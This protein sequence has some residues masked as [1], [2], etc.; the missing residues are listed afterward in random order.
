[1]TQTEDWVRIRGDQLVAA[2]RRATTCASPRS[3]GRRTSSIT[4]RC[5]SS[6]IPTDTEVFVDE[7]FSAARRR[8]WRCSAMRR[9]RAG[10][11]AHGTTQ[12]ATSPTLVDARAT[13]ATWR[14]SRAARIRASPRDHFV[15]FE[16]GRERPRR[17][18]TCS[19]SRGLDLS[20]RQQHQRRH[21]AGRARRSRAASRSKRR[22]RRAVGD[23]RRRISDFPP[24]RTRPCS[25]D[26]RACRRARDRLRLRTNLEIYWDCAGAWPS[27]VRPGATTKRLQS[28]S[29]ELR[30][31]GF[32]Q[33]TSPRGDAP[34]TPDL[35]AAREHDA[36][37]GAIS[38]A[39]TRASATCASCWPASTI[40]T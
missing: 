31:R 19:W 9:R 17:A 22:T 6:T 23:G 11:R 21:R 13:A 12:G 26:L 16:L 5:W 14:R 24:A 38:S 32:S 40:A 8:R 2:R 20:H 29:A 36:S 15:E 30:F 10:A 35:R 7:R 1:M 25:I 33:T 39:T 18:G 27:G 28:S 37:A 3:C 34:E 4:S